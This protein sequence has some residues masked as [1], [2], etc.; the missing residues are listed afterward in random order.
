MFDEASQASCAVLVNVLHV[1]DLGVLDPSMEHARC[2]HGGGI[3]L[4]LDLNDGRA[5]AGRVAFAQ[6]RDGLTEVAQIDL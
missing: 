1:G 3:R 5:A 4:L 2:P 6:P